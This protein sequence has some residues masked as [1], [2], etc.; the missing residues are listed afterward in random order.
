MVKICVAFTVCLSDQVDLNKIVD[1]TKK[2]EKGVSELEQLLLKFPTRRGY[3]DSLYYVHS[4]FR[5]RAHHRSA[6]HRS[7]LGHF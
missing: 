1:F 7:T 2:H 6:I 4:N 5:A 3:R